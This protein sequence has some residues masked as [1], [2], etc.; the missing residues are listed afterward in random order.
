MAEQFSSLARYRSYRGE[1]E[2]L[3]AVLGYMAAMDCRFAL[4]KHT[5]TLHGSTSVSRLRYTQCKRPSC[6]NIDACGSPFLGR[7]AFMVSEPFISSASV[8]TGGITTTMS[9]M[10]SPLR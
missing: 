7:F 6:G 1:A 3:D 4:R 9:A 5:T 2:F 10:I 8:L